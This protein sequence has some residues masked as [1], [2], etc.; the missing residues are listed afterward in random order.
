[1]RAVLL[2]MLLIPLACVS[3]E[4]TT[5]S[6]DRYAEGQVWSYRTRPHETNSR[7]HVVRIDRRLDGP[8]IYHLYVDGLSIINPHAASGV[9][10]HLPHC[11]VGAETLDASVLA[12]VSAG[13]AQSPSIS[14]GYSVWREAFDRGEGGYFTIPMDR[15]LR[16]LE[17]AVARPA[18]DG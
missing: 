3:H 16:H 8:P 18:T 9:Q 13:E 6:H 5:M 4:E 15:I 11:P 17:S 2:L 12:L 10:A 1:M 14:E 7:I